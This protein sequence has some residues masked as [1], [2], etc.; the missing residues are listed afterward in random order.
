MGGDAG[1]TTRL[2]G[3]TIAGLPPMGVGTNGR[4]AWGQTA[5]FSEVTDWYTEEMV[6]DSDGMPTATMFRGEEQPLTT[7]D[8][9]VEVAN[10]D[11]I[12]SVGRTE[13][14]VRFETFDGR[15]INSIEGRMVTADETLG[16]GETRLNVNGD[17]IVPSDIDGDGVISAISFKYGPLTEGY[18]LLRAF[19]KF[20]FADTVEDFRQATRHFI[21]YGGWMMASDAAGS[22]LYTGYHAVPCRDYLPRDGSNVWIDG[23]DPRRLIDGTQYPAWDIPARPRRAAWTI[24]RSPPEAPKPA[25]CPSTN[26]PRPSIRPSSTSSTHNNDPASIATDNDLFDD[27]Y[28]IGGPWI[29][30]YRAARDD[31]LLAQAV[32]D[33]DADIARMAA[34]QGDH[35]SNLGEDFLPYLLEA[36]EAARTAAAG[37]PAAGSAEERLAAMWAAASADYTEVETRM[38]E[39]NSAGFPTPSGV[40]TFYHTPAAGDGRHAVATSIFQAWIRVF[41]SLV[42]DDEHINRACRLR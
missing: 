40:E 3:S 1:E 23:A 29:E 13:T 28:Y 2:V 33:G 37:T 11:S 15:M 8:E 27:P 16:A 35:H 31:E 4:I 7:V 5:Y 14:F 20:Q 38:T 39:W 26:G 36:I 19:R 12:G 30:G 6:L 24:R 10:I 22:V 9:S 41:F 34:I 25:R 18:S 21:G 32:M 42:L 17:L